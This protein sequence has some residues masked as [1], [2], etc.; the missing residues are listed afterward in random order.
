MQLVRRQV[1]GGRTL[2]VVVLVLDV[3]IVLDNLLVRVLEAI[4]YARAAAYV[5]SHSDQLRRTAQ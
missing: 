3:H 4:V 1:A 2:R 5:C